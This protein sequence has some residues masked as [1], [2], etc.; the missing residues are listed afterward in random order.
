MN[1]HAIVSGVIA[2]VNPT[3]FCTLQMSVGFSVAP[4]GSQVPQY[5]TF[6]N[7]PCQIQ[8]LSYQDLQHID[9]LNIQGTRRAVYING[10]W[11]GL[12]RATNK[13]GDLLTTPDGTVWLVAMV[14]EHWPDWTKV[15]VTQQDGA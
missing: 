12:N 10:N 8:A 1:L 11:E 7:V 6:A 2:A 13:G 14:L 15:V 4:D 5:A 9:G 3:V